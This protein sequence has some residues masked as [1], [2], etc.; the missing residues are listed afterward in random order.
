MIVAIIPARSGSK[1]IPDKN[2]R[3]FCGQ[4]MIQYSIEAAQ[5]S[6]VFD[7]VIVTTDCPNI[8]RLAVDLGAEAPFLRPPELSD[9]H[10]PTI[11]VIKHALQTLNNLA[12]NTEPTASE[13]VGRN[14]VAFSQSRNSANERTPNQTQETP[15]NLESD[16][17]S[18]SPPVRSLRPTPPPTADVGRNKVAFSRSRNSSNITLAAQATQVRDKT[19]SD[20]SSGNPPVRPLRPTAQIYQRHPTNEHRNTEHRTLAIAYACCIYATAPFITGEDIRTGLE[21]LQ[22]D[23]TAKFAFPVTTYPYS[24]HRSLQLNDDRVSMFYP[25]HEQTRSQDLTEAYHDAG[26]FYWG[27]AEAWRQETSVFSGSSIGIPIPRHRVQDIDTPEDFERAE[28]LF[29]AMTQMQ[30]VS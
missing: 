19:T 20:C 10:T 6:G 22:S 23:P 17:S 18:G 3:D 16:R 12:K 8:A 13:N 29:R 7:R 30:Q 26:Q 27:T 9:D 1:R 11:P 25:E 21:K 2:I 5:E 14:K 24:I 4:P 15:C 28:L